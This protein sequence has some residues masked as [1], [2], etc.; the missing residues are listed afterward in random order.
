MP[1]PTDVS[2]QPQPSKKEL[3][4][5]YIN[6]VIGFKEAAKEHQAAEKSLAEVSL[7]ADIATLQAL[8]RREK[9]AVEKLRLCRRIVNETRERYT[10]ATE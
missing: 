6:A 5:E 2:A 3:Y 10:I 7:H 4:G 9:E 1:V 8:V